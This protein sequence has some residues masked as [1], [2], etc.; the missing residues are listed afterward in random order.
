MTS[1]YFFVYLFRELATNIPDET[2]NVDVEA[3]FE[4]E[5]QIAKVSANIVVR[6]HGGS[7]KK[8]IFPIPDPIIYLILFF[9]QKYTVYD[10]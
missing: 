4:F 8:I 9:H 3:V 10:F 7:V 1:H 6:I 5:A 2:L